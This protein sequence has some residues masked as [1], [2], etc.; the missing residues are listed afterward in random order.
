MMTMMRKRMRRRRLIFRRHCASPR[1][2]LTAQAGF[3][4][5]RK[6][7]QAASALTGLQ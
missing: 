3:G 7:M 2:S 6:R 1:S 5:G 4:A